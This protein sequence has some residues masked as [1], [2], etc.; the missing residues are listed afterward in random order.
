MR[1][2][3]RCG[4]ECGVRRLEARGKLREAAGAVGPQWRGAVGCGSRA[5]RRN[6][7]GSSEATARGNRACH[8]VERPGVAGCASVDVNQRT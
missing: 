2:S 6:E 8:A 7:P 5:K 3:R 1:G 4:C